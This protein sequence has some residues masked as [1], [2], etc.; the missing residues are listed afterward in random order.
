MS[1]WHKKKAKLLAKI[2]KQ[3]TRAAFL[4]ESNY[5]RNFGWYI[6]L[7]GEI[8]GELIKCRFEDMFWDSYEIIPKDSIHEK[9]LFDSDKILEHPFKF[10][11]K[12]LDEY[13]ENAFLAGDQNL[14]LTKKR[15][16]VRALYL[17]NNNILT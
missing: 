7:N 5:G 14:L 13:A 3:S 12:R 9:I 11:N 17:T 16:V 4:A 15:L 8:I 6:E 10:K 1:S 2:K